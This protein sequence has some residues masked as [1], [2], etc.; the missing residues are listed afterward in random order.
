MSIDD[1]KKPFAKDERELEN[2]IQTVR[3][4]RPDRK[5][6]H[7]SNEKRETTYDKESIDKMKKNENAS[8]KGNLQILGNIGS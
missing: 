6:R 5:M 4:Y 8:R 3:I 7:A 1:K 2:V